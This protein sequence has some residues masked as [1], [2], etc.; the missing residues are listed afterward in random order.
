MN[1][2]VTITLPE[3]NPIERSATTQLLQNV[4]GASKEE[5]RAIAKFLKLSAADRA[6]MCE[7][8]QNDKA[9]RAL[10]SNWEFLKSMI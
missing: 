8:I 3:E 5:R 7:I 2:T 6:R 10:E 1:S 9:Q 4:A